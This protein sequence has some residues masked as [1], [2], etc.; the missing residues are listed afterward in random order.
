VATRLAAPQ[1]LSLGDTVTPDVAAQAGGLS[2]SDI[3]GEPVLASTAPASCL[4]S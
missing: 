2:A 3:V 1:L 4:P